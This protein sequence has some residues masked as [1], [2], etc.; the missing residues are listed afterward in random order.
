MMSKETVLPAKRLQGEVEVPADKSISHR[1]LMISALAEGVSEIT[2]LL[3]AEDV[4]S[5]LHCLEQLGVSIVLKDGKYLV[6]GVGKTGFKSPGYELDAGNSGTTLRILPGI[7][8]GQGFTATLTG[9]ASVR[10]RPVERVLK[11]LREMGAQAR[12]TVGYAPIVITGGNLRGIQYTTEVPSAQVKSAILLAGLLA[13]G[14]TAVSEEYKSRDHTEIMLDHFGAEI[15]IDGN[16]VTVSG[17]SN[18]SARE[19]VVPGDFSSAFYF[20][21]GALLV[22]QSEVF[23]PSVGI[24]PTRSGVATVL[25]RMGAELID[26]KS[27]RTLNGELVSDITVRSAELKA[28]TIERNEIPSLIDELPVIAVLATQAK[29]KTI[30]S[31]AEELRVKETDRISTVVSELKKMGAKIEEKPDGFVVEGPAKLKGAEVDSHGDHRLAMSL[32]VAAL[33]A[34]G[35]TVINNAEAVAVSFPGF[36]KAL[37]KLTSNV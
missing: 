28:T 4:L 8:A 16:T 17:D 3:K 25:E 34:D 14:K 19:V 29:G 37:N 13:E 31:G 27:T 20:A 10:S 12:S 24:N 7:L 5:T 11:P 9:D 36:F 35:P 23:L 1:A 18:L 15:E 26:A 6:S 21:A 30:V 33:A 22:P 32:A 2:N